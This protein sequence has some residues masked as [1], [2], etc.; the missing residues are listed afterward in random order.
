[1]TSRHP[2]DREPQITADARLEQEF[3]AS[4]LPRTMKAA[5][6]LRV[7]LADRTARLPK[8]WPFN[9]RVLAFLLP[10]FRADVER[11][12]QAAGPSMQDLFEPHQLEHIDESLE[13]MLQRKVGAESG[14]NPGQDKRSM[15]ML[16]TAVDRLAEALVSMELR[17]AAV[18]KRLPSGRGDKPSGG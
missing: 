6:L 17:L 1:M 2:Q 8:G 7:E 4:C 10:N 18:E 14:A 5:R 9:D 15:Q 12:H 13:M 11:F 3:A 16:L